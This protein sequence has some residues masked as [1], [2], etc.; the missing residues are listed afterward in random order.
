M[1]LVAL[2]TAAA[3]RAQHRPARVPL[4]YGVLGL[5]ARLALAVYGR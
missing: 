2:G 3:V 1:G 4:A 5:A